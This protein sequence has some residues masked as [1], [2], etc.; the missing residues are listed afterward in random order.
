MMN[1]LSLLDTLFGD[2]CMTIPAMSRP[3][4]AMPDVDVK[5]TKDSYIFMMD[6]PG[7]SDS[8][9]DL[10]IKDSEFTIASTKKSE[11]EEKKS[12][13]EK[14]LLRERTNM[15]FKR[16]FSLPKDTDQESAKAS[17]SNGVLTVSFARKAAPETKKIAINVA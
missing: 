1:E 4:F 8:D 5:Q 9:I 16:S 2:G 12:D 3:S 15:S 17:F 14:W 7:M 13:E 11:K 10:S 6:L